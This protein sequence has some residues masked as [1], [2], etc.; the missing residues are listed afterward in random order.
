MFLYINQNIYNFT[1]RFI[2][3]FGHLQVLTYVTLEADISENEHWREKGLK[4]RIHF[5]ILFQ[6]I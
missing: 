4:Q 6:F 2:S 3:H 5:A 1:A